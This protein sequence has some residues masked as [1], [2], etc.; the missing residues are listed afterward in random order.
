MLPAFDAVT[1]YIASLNDPLIVLLSTFIDSYTV[2]FYAIALLFF[3]STLRRERRLLKAILAISLALVITFALKYAIEIPRPCMLNPGEYY[4]GVCP[5]AP[6]FS[7][8][9]GHTAISSSFL[10]PML[11][12]VA[13]PIFFILNLLVGFS[14]INLG[15]HFLNDVMAGFVIGFFCYDIANRLLSRTPQPL[16]KPS[17]A[18]DTR[19]ELRRQLLHIIVGIA[20]ISTIILFTHLYKANG[21]IYAEFMVFIGLQVMLMA[22]NSRMQGSRNRLLEPLFKTFER[23]GVSPGYG[24]FWYGMGVLFS[25][26]FISDVNFLIA[27]II[28]L[29][30][31]DGI[32][33]IVG[34]HG[35]AK[36]P[37]NPEKSLEGTASFFAST[38]VLSFPFIGFLSIPFALVT[39]I[40]ESL[41][42]KF[43][44]NFTIPLAAI[45]MS[46]I[47]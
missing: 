18:T 45:T 8:P 24:A 41:P 29:G 40:V 14:R 1:R 10:A 6:D 42:L 16:S 27:A 5:T 25:F 34:R 12:T 36:N 15:V 23:A 47:L 20:I 3:A 43:D 33:T 13:F 30:I 35:R 44:D 21:P 28:A 32:A 7:F 38:A 9:S 4:K 46:L 17:R 11:G 31:G 22:I 2:I 39:A 19:F 26:V 37:L